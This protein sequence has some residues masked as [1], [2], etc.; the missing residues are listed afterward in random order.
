MELVVVPNASSPSPEAMDALERGNILLF[1]QTPF[2]ISNEDR[3]VLLRGGQTDAGFHKNIAY[4]PL[5]GKLTGL[6]STPDSEKR[7]IHRAISN[8]SKSAIELLGNMFAPYRVS[9]RTD[10]ASFRSIEEEGRV[11]PI[12]KRNDLLHTDAF[13][14]RPTNGGLIL[15]IFSNINPEKSRDWITSEPFAT[16][17]PKYAKD[18]GLNCIA[19]E[20]DSPKKKIT[21]C[22]A[23]YGVAGDRPLT[24]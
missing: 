19:G 5:S 2:E 11:L 6:K 15:R 9:W 3:E 24:V 23:R 1:P 14:T 21:T 10:Y 22:A 4:R 12:K 16:L 8:Y 7:L 20:A 13:P 17:A 18:A